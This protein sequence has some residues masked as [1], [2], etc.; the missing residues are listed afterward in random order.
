[1]EDFRVNSFPCIFC[2]NLKSGLFSLDITS[3]QKL[4]Y[5]YFLIFGF[6]IFMELIS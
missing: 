5:Q 3:I 6:R 1:M 2:F 4:S